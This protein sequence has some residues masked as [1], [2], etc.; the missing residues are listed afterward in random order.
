[1]EDGSNQV[2]EG[3]NHLDFVADRKTGCPEF[4]GKLHI[5]LLFIAAQGVR[6]SWSPFG[7]GSRGGDCG[8]PRPPLIRRATKG[9]ERGTRGQGEVRRVQRLRGPIEE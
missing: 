6:F 5:M 9:L 3:S 4:R 1:M 7:G 2:M 8:I